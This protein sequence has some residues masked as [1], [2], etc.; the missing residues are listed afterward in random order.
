M[1]FRGWHHVFLVFA[2]DTLY[3]RAILEITRC[4]RHIAAFQLLRRPGKF[5]ETQA[6]LTTLVGVRSMT[7]VAAVGKDRTHLAIEV[8][9]CVGCVNDG[10]AEQAEQGSGVRGAHLEGWRH[11]TPKPSSCRTMNKK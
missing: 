7:T 8:H 10:C 11:S 5:I 4:D 1:Q 3:Q 9:R 2:Q 6:G